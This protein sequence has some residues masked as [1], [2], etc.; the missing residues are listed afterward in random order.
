MHVAC[1]N[2]SVGLGDVVK[3]EIT[4]ANNDECNKSA[5]LVIV[6]HNCVI[7]H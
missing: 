5:L 6:L 7:A 1:K 3:S 4:Y 2:K